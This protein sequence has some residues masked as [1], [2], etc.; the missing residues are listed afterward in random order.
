MFTLLILDSILATLTIRALARAEMVCPTAMQASSDP[1]ATVT[2]AQVTSDL[3]DVTLSLQVQ[4]GLEG[5]LEA[6]VSAL[7]ET[8]DDLGCNELAGVWSY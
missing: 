7:T 5:A 2:R 1:E 3:L 6:R 4:C 8:L